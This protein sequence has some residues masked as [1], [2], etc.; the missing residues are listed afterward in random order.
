M[1][2]KAKAKKN[3]EFYTTAEHVRIIFEHYLKNYNFKDKVIYCPFD[4]DESEFV[5]Y[6]TVNKLSLGYKEFL[7]TSDDYKNH[8][9][10]FER[11]DVIVTNPPFSL[12][13]KEILP[14][15]RKYNIDYFLFGHQLT[16][17]NYYLKNKDL[18]IIRSEFSDRENFY[19]RPNGEETCVNTCYLTNIDEVNYKNKMNLS[20]KID[21]YPHLNYII[22]IDSGEKWPYFKHIKD[23]PFDLTSPCYVP[24]SVLEWRYV[25]FFDIISL[26]NKN[27]YIENGDKIMEKALVKL[28]NKYVI[29]T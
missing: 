4:S 29:I 1:L 16:I 21:D 20:K 12:L 14:F 6:L 27:L 22:N 5:K 26:K 24:F 28:K 17:K 7:Y 25:Q 3:D 13:V 2:S 18:K 15:L 8:L 10:L 9:N 11:A 23:V 19:R